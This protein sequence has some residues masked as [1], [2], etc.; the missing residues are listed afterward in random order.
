MSPR[1]TDQV[2]SPVP[3]SLQAPLPSRLHRTTSQVSVVSVKAQSSR[4]EEKPLLSQRTSTRSRSSS[5][6]LSPFLKTRSKSDQSVQ[7]GGRDEEQ[8]ATGK[9]PSRS[10]T[11][12][13]VF[14]RKGKEKASEV[15]EENV[16]RGDV[17]GYGKSEEVTRGLRRLVRSHTLG[18]P[19]FAREGDDRVE[20]EVKEVKPPDRMSVLVYQLKEE[21]R[22]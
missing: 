6:P 13:L 18:N 7:S 8:D 11:P 16:E 19:S 14:S 12:G 21:S 2:S 5:V 22:R 1:S 17:A 3:K 9:E 10:S 4:V 20:E 15:L